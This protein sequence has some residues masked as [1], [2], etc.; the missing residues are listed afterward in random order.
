MPQRG[1]VAEL[2]E[3][4]RVLVRS[5][6]IVILTPTPINAIVVCETPDDVQRARTRIDS[7]FGVLHVT[8]SVEIHGLTFHIDFT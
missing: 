4:F 2:S 5:I 6:G 7:A 3:R 1:E 8:A